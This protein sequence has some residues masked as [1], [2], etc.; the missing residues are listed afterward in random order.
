MIEL[1]VLAVG[2]AVVSSAVA[3]V[4]ARRRRAEAAASTPPVASEG[5]W[6]AAGGLARAFP[7][8]RTQHE[9][10]VG[11]AAFVDGLI[12]GHYYLGDGRR[13]GTAEAPSPGDDAELFDGSDSTEVLAVTA[14]PSLDEED[15]TAADTEVALGSPFALGDHGA[16]WGEPETDVDDLDDGFS[17]GLHGYAPDGL[18]DGSKDGLEDD[19]GVGGGFDGGFDDGFGDG[20]DDDW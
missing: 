1:V 17:D 11:D 16:T 10:D 18:D 5:T 8:E 20:L 12:V 3:G 2:V 13:E 6:T 15:G 19:D 4:A 14:D 9:H 7:L